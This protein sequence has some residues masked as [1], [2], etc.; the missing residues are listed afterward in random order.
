MHQ[1]VRQGYLD[2]AEAEPERIKRIDASQPLEEVVEDT[3]EI[4]KS[5]L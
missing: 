3:W 5:Y 1:R 2:L 4:I